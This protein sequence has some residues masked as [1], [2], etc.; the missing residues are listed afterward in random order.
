MRNFAGFPLV[1]QKLSPLALH[2]QELAQEVLHEQEKETERSGE[3]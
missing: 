1:K 2:I 3:L